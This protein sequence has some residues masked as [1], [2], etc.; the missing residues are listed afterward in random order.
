MM[1]THVK[2]AIDIN[3]SETWRFWVLL[4]QGLHS[5]SSW[6]ALDDQQDIKATV[7]LPEFQGSL[8]V[9]IY[10][11]SCSP[12]STPNPAVS[13]LPITLP[14]DARRLNKA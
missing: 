13:I 6:N 7:L 12:I 8:V 4:S 2:V 11:A 5:I 14:F 10:T 3:I 1:Y 9:A